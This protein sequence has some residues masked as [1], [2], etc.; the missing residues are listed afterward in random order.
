M[1][2]VQIHFIRFVQIHFIVI[3]WI[4]TNFMKGHS[5]Q[6]LFFFFGE[7]SS[8]L[9][10]NIHQLPYWIFDKMI[11]HKPHAFMHEI[12]NGMEGSN[13]KQQTCISVYGD[14][15]GSSLNTFLLL[16]KES[17]LEDQKLSTQLV[18]GN[19]CQRVGFVLC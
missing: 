9:F 18:G 6:T 15:R 13:M 11:M 1:K 19:S 7:H 5:G 8:Q 12:S 17:R 16:L 14:R 3:K 10:V 2:F 4:Y